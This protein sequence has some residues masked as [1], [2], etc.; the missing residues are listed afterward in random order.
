[1]I[2][3]DQGRCACLAGT[4]GAALVDDPAVIGVNDGCKANAIMHNAQQIFMTGPSERRN[5][6]HPRLLV[7]SPRRRRSQTIC[8]FRV[9]G[10]FRGYYAMLNLKL[11]LSYDAA[12]ISSAGRPSSG[13]RTV[14]ETLERPSPS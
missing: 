2:A 9:F 8:P 6:E 13:K 11:T 10:V 14:Q 12:P 4:R 1:V 7:E 5:D 3:G